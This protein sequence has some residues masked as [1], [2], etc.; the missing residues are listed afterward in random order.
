[1]LLTLRV[2]VPAQVHALQAEVDRVKQSK[3]LL[4]RTMLAQLNEARAQTRTEQVCVCARGC[5][6]AG[7]GGAHV[8]W[9]S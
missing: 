5:L 7:G 1:M 8:G 9:S 2:W 6:G 4:Q 3:A